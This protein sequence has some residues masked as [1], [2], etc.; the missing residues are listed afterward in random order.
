MLR[1][2]QE[3]PRRPRRRAA[4]SSSNT[5]SRSRPG[6]LPATDACSSADSRAHEAVNQLFQPVNV[7]LV[8]MCWILNDADLFG[9]IAARFFCSWLLSSLSGISWAKDEGYSA[10]ASFLL[11]LSDLRVILDWLMLFIFR[12]RAAY[13][14]WFWRKRLQRSFRWALMMPPCCWR[15]YTLY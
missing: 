7:L 3:Q 12:L 9:F 10:I 5:S 15:N 8:S 11:H 6:V 2:P 4:P 13:S 1:A 14:V